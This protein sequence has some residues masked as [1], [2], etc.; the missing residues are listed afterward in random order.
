MSRKLV[1]TGATRG[2]GHAI[3]RVFASEGFDI[4]FCSRNPQH[5]QTL[6]EELISAYGI[7]A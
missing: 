2:I 1:I 3:A 7:K 5:L 6:Q 4:A